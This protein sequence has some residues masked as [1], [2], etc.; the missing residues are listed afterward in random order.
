VAPQVVF[1]PV[2]V[3]RQFAGRRARLSLG[4]PAFIIECGGS[5]EFRGWRVRRQTRFCDE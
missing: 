3:P 4:W 1:K 5:A 2:L